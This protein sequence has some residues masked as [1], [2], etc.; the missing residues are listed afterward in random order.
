MP[1]RCDVREFNS[2]LEKVGFENK[3]PVN[4]DGRVIVEKGHL[5]SEWRR[6]TRKHLVPY[7][8]EEVELQNEG[9]KL[10]LAGTLYV[11]LT[12][13]KRP[14]PITQSPL[15]IYLTG[16]KRNLPVENRF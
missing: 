6:S 5:G 10:D 15:S 9:H 16:D 11:P 1:P 2:A 14:N 4:N 12:Q 7:G 3:D 8:L 13:Y